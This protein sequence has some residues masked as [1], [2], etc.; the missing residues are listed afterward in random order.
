MAS[1]HA[2]NGAQQGSTVLLVESP[3]KSK[4]LQ[5]FLGSDY[6]VQ[7]SHLCMRKATA[8]ASPA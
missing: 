2:A 8:D 1:V 4:K 7:C 6:K 3:A 5:Q